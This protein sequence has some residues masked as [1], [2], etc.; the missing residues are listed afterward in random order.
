MQKH[1]NKLRPMQLQ[2]LL[3]TKPPLKQLPR[4][5]LP[6]R[7]N[8]KR[9]ELLE[10]RS[11]Q[12]PLKLLRLLPLLLLRRKPPQ[13]GENCLRKLRRPNKRQLRLKLLPLLLP[14]KQNTKESRLSSLPKLKQIREHRKPPCGRCR[15]YKKLRREKESQLRKPKRQK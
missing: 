5:K 4:P 15:D 7:R 13:R 1:S 14:S 11:T 9:R 8:F 10:K 2:E 12:M 6:E 3:Q